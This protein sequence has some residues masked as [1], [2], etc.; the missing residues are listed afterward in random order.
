M[1]G[2]LGSPKEDRVEGCGREG[3]ELALEGDNVLARALQ[4][5]LQHLPLHRVVRLTANNIINYP[6]IEHDVKTR[7]NKNLYSKDVS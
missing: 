2:H 5:L 3:V 6:W 7:I 4:L 1:S